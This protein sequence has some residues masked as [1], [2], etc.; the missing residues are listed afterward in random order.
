MENVI[1]YQAQRI[2]ALER[3]IKELDRQLSDAKEILSE[4]LT[5]FKNN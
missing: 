2:L 1:E 5:D 4:I 3:R